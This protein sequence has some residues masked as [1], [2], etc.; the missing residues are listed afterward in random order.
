MK[1]GFVSTITTDR[2]DKLVTVKKILV[3][4]NRGGIPKVVALLNRKDNIIEPDSFAEKIKK[5]LDEGLKHWVSVGAE[6]KQ[7]NDKFKFYK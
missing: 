2:R 7:I 5:T 4:W 1:N 3:E 6:I